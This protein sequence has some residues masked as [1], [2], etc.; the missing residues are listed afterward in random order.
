LR[1]LRFKGRR[2]VTI[3]PGGEVVSDPQRFAF[4]AFEDV[5]VSLH[6]Q[7]TS[8][9]ATAHPTA[10]QTSYASA[11]GSGDATRDESGAPYV[12]TL[13]SW[14]FLTDL[15]VRAPRRVGG[16]VALGDSITDGFFSPFDGN[17]RYPDLLAR[18]LAA[19]GGPPLAFQN[20]GISGN[21]VLGPGPLVMF[22]PGLLA[23]L[24][25]DALDQAGARIVILMEGTNDIGA[26]PFSSAA[27]VI[28]GLEQ[29]TARLHDAGLRVILGTIPPCKDFALAQHG[30]P[31]AI[32]KR[33]A[34]ND[35]IRTGADA[36]GVVDF[37]AVLRDPADPDRLLPAY[38]S[39][40]HLHPGPAGYAAMAD[41]VD[42]SFFDD[43]PCR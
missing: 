36:D 26:P 12:R 11:P 4:E 35:W 18:R 5:V 15:E 7:G 8:G 19:A 23:R 6:I 29:I 1:R 3:P 10:L 21:D 43:L 40:D 37:H 33:N 13:V 22:G 14:P 24:D 27:E 30:A 28:A 25:Q 17:G 2:A 16:V 31:E 38:D 34:I 42:L 39:G 32:A 9:R 41:A 20:E